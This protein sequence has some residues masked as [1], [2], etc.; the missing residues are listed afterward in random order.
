MSDMSYGYLND[1]GSRLDADVRRRQVS[2]L[3]HVITPAAAM[4]LV[5][6]ASPQVMFGSAATWLSWP[7]NLMLGLIIGVLIWDVRALLLRRCGSTSPVT[8][9]V[10]SMAQAFH[11]AEDALGLSARPPGPGDYVGPRSAA[12]SNDGSSLMWRSCAVL[13]LAALAYAASQPENGTSREWLEHIVTGLASADSD[14]AWREAAHAVAA[15]TAPTVNSSFFHAMNMEQR[16]R[17][18]VALVMREAILGA[19]VAVQR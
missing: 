2:Q 18:S 19:A 4:C 8:V 13:P 14:D 17:D 5:L 7:W 12:G 6:T 9:P 10:D 1:F 3:L 11:F 16:Q 15:T